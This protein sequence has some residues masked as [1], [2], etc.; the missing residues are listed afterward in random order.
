M[1][2]L[3]QT[4]FSFRHTYLRELK[5]LLSNNYLPLSFMCEYCVV[6]ERRLSF[7]CTQLRFSELY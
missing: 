7:V 6:K 2:Q 3:I 4:N 1:I 5:V